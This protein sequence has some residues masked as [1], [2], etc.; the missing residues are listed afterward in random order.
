MS[1]VKQ[2]HIS[3]LHCN[4]SIQI[5]ILFGEFDSFVISK[6]EGKQIEC[7]RCGERTSCNK[8]NMRFRT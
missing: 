8:D 5:A 4:E 3:C 2:L 7:P 1:E 6:M